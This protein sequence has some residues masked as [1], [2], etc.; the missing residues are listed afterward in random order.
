MQELEVPFSYFLVWEGYMMILLI[1]SKTMFS[2]F[3]ILFVSIFHIVSFQAGYF[4][5]PFL[6]SL[7]YHA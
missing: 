2:K 4:L 1:S 3:R 6:P 7:L 5:V